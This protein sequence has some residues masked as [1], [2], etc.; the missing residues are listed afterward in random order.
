MK[1]KEEVDLREP[2]V[3]TVPGGFSSESEAIFYFPRELTPK[4]K[5]E[6][7]KNRILGAVLVFLGI[8]LVLVGYAGTEMLKE[9]KGLYLLAA[10]LAAVGAGLFFYIPNP[11]LPGLT[12]GAMAL[13]YLVVF[14]AILMNV[15]SAF[16]QF[17]NDDLSGSVDRIMNSL[18]TMSEFLLIAGA[19]VA[20]VGGNILKDSIRD[21][22]DFSPAVI[23]LPGKFGR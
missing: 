15:F 9:V 11:N 14:V 2:T 1:K 23:V 20:R 18:P 13:V 7:M 6:I 19:I 4:A 8:A 17:D 5:K 16:A 22:T 10:V 21:I 3:L 12:R